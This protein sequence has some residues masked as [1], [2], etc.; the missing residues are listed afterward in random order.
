MSNYY[1]END[2]KNKSFISSSYINFASKSWEIK[3]YLKVGKH[4]ATFIDTGK[5]FIDF[6]K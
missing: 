2:N 1:Y 5:G 3:H 6:T 4:A